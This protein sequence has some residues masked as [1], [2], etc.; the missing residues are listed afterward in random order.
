MWMRESYE[1]SFGEWP[2]G[3]KDRLPCGR[4]NSDSA[5]V[6]GD[7][8]PALGQAETESS[9]RIS[10]GE[11]RIESVFA[12]SGCQLVPVVEQV[13]FQ[14]VPALPSAVPRS[15]SDLAAWPDCSNGVTQEFDQDDLELLGVEGSVEG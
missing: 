11:E 1:R 13:E 2:E 15:E 9:A 3:A 4:V 8:A 12:L 5:S 7:N 6:T 14:P 10:A